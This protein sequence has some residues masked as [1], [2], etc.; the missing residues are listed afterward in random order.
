M[1]TM[2]LFML[3]ALAGCEEKIS[4]QLKGCNATASC[5][6]APTGSI[7]AEDAE[8]DWPQG[9]TGYTLNAELSGSIGDSTIQLDEV[10]DTTFGG[11][12]RNGEICRIDLKSDEVFDYLIEGET[13]TLS[14][15][16]EVR[17][18][19]R[20]DSVWR[21]DGGN[22]R[23]YQWMELTINDIDDPFQDDVVK[24][25]FECSVREASIDA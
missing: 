15:N 13:L 24:L 18:F 4:D 10:R 6:Q 5:V 23:M 22:E 17:I 9:H 1:K 12:L 11:P 16:G 2:L 3:F 14:Q 7:Q 8:D 25:K 20:R 21:W 19:N